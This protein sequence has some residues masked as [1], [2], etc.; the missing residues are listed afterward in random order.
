MR[1]AAR[2]HGR[3][4]NKV[5]AG[6]FGGEKGRGVYVKEIWRFPV[7]SMAGERLT[8]AKI[9]ELGIEGDRKIL[10]RGAN[11]R[12]IT[13]RTH[14]KLLGLKGTLGSDGLARINGY[15]WNTPEA[16]TLVHDAAG[17]GAELFYYDGPERFD[18]RP[19]LVATDGAIAA[20]G[21]DGRR[22]RPNIVVGGVE[23]LAERDWPGKYLCIG[24]VVIGVQDLRGRCVMT[25]FDP[26]TL[27]QDKNVLYEIAQKFGG[28]LALNCF[29][30]HG[31]EISSGSEVELLAEAELS[32]SVGKSSS[33]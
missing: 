10:V 21:H 20:F 16:L 28:Q 3:E 32:F 2:L 24:E 11:G 22:L 17:P 19:L 9:V 14:H 13:S 7:K 12:V 18:V 25:T 27:E 8:S 30:I 4:K 31:G 26:D 15:L 29:V 23:G 6:Q 1:K 33:L 5:A